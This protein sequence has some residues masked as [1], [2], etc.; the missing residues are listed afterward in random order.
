MERYKK[1]LCPDCQTTLGKIWPMEYG[2]IRLEL[3][4]K[5]C[6]AAKKIH[7]EVRASSAAPPISVTPID[8]QRVFVG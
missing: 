6:K 2:Q 7:I 4:C 1:I 5:K 8:S 3:R